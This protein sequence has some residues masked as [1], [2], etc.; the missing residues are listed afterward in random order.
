[1][2]HKLWFIKNKLSTATKIKEEVNA[3]KEENKELKDQ[4]EL[5]KEDAVFFIADDAEEAD[6]V[7]NALEGEIT[8]F[9]IVDI[10]RYF[11]KIKFRVN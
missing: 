10:R 9:Y 7:V 5:L 4:N 11:I 6:D 3:T 2:N 1:M 8:V